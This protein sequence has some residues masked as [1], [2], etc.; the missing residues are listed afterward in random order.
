MK[1]IIQLLTTLLLAITL[2]ATPIMAEKSIQSLNATGNSTREILSSSKTFYH[3]YTSGYSVKIKINYTYRY[4]SSNSSGKYITGI[5]GGTITKVSGWTSI[6]SYSINTNSVKYT[7]NSQYATVEYS[8]YGSM[9]AGNN[10]YDSGA[11]T[12]SM[13]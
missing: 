7:S 6:G 9:G 13:F 5:T 10:I 11:V 8:Y 12:L 2:D 4:E 1:K 3:T